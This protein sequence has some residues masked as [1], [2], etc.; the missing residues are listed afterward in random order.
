MS[1]ISKLPTGTV[2][3]TYKVAV[4]VAVD[5]KKSGYLVYKS[6]TE[7]EMILDSQTEKKHTKTRLCNSTQRIPRF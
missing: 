6:E 4:V 3:H 1:S 5:S 2:T 7:T